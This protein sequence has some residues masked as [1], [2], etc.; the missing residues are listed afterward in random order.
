MN[1]VQVNCYDA[2]G[3]LKSKEMDQ[4][5]WEERD[6]HNYEWS[7]GKKPPEVEWVLDEEEAKRSVFI[8]DQQ[9][10]EPDAADGTNVIILTSSDVCNAPAIQWTGTVEES[11]VNP[12]SEHK[13]STKLDGSKW[14]RS[15]ESV[16]MT[17]G[18]S[19]LPKSFNVKVSDINGAMMNGKMPLNENGELVIVAPSA[20]R[21]PAVAPSPVVPQLSSTERKQLR[22]NLNRE[23]MSGKSQVEK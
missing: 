16:C 19:G 5:S 20:E 10:I 23:M 1:A 13:M 8:G 12:D 9:A 7:G 22:R 3:T 21:A 4:D 18:K 6:T 2:D 15:K 11:E 17:M 14:V